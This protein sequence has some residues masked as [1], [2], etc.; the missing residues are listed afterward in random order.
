MI[1]FSSKD[2]WITVLHRF[3]ILTNQRSAA[4]KEAKLIDQKFVEGVFKQKSVLDGQL[5]R[6][7][8]FLGL[9]LLIIYLSV[10]GGDFT[11]PIINMK[12]S[13][14]PSILEISVFLFSANLVGFGVKF[15]DDLILRTT[16]NS[17]MA[18]HFGDDLL[19]QNMMKMSH[20]PDS[21]Y[22]FLFL[23]KY[24]TPEETIRPKALAKVFNVSMSIVAASSFLAM[25]LVPIA[26]L[27]FFAIPELEDGKITMMISIFAYLSVLFFL[28]CIA[29][30]VLPLPFKEVLPEDKKTT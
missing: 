24:Q 21:T 18:S 25:Y 6:I 15:L 16:I 27:L 20:Y 13:E 3:Q 23:R 19:I 10:N 11:I 2:V 1:K 9:Y 12:L 14:I 22:R 29:T 17:I 5:Q 7:F 28:G 8:K 26:F 4:V 30:F